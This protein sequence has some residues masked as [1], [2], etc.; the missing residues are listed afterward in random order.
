MKPPNQANAALAG[1]GAAK[2]KADNAPAIAQTRPETTAN[3]V[4]GNQL[5][6]QLD[7][8]RGRLDR[9][10][11]LL[12]QS[13]DLREM[14]WFGCDLDLMRDQVDAFKRACRPSYEEAAS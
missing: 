10:T 11:D 3:T 13:F 6:A 5:I 8:T 2:E 4:G 9:A 1:G 7:R 14:L 12:N